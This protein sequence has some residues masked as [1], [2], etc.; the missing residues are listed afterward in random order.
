MHHPKFIV[1]TYCVRVHFIGG[2]GLFLLA[3]CISDKGF[4]FSISV[5]AVLSRSI[6]DDQ[7]LNIVLPTHPIPMLDFNVVF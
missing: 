4:S 6:R 2:G 5:V 3:C 7:V 1:P